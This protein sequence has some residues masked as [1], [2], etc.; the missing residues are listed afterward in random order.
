M[1]VSDWT[2][3]AF[4]V[5]RA[6]RFFVFFFSSFFFVNVFFLIGS[7]LKWRAMNAVQ[8][9]LSGTSPPP[10][11]RWERLSPRSTRLF[12]FFFSVWSFIRMEDV[13]FKLSSASKWY[14]SVLEVA[15]TLKDPLTP[16][17]HSNC[18]TES[19]AGARIT[20]FIT[21]LIYFLLL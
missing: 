1:K 17:P 16:H 10:C 13:N 14:N 2:I 8:G 15:N 7:E 3:R 21:Q 4:D 12:F 20:C 9:S 18:T 5:G 6:Q 19:V 11:T